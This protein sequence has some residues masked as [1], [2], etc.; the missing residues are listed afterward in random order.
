M[1]RKGFYYCLFFFVVNVSDIPPAT[2]STLTLSSR[3]ESD[4]CLTAT[5][6]TQGI[7]VA[8]GKGF[9]NGFDQLADPYGI[10]LDDN[11]T[12]YIADRSNHRIIMWEQNA[13]IGQLV[14]G[15]AWESTRSM[16]LNMPQDVV[17]DKNGTMYISDGGNRRVVRWRRDAEE[18][19]VIID[20]IQ[21]VGIGQDDEGSIYVSEYADGRITKW[22]MNDDE[23]NGQVIATQ[24]RQSNFL[25]VDQ[26][27]S[28]YSV[29]YMAHRIVKVSEDAEEPIIVAGQSDKSGRDLDQ[30]AFPTGVFVDQLG[31]IYVADTDNH[32]I[33]RW[34][35]GATSGNLIIGEHG[36]GSESDQLHNPSDLFLDRYGNLYVTDTLN[37]RVQKFMIDKSSCLTN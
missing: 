29:G 13:T 36:V 32:R 34:P 21:A 17:V 37:N 23:L 8:G 25:F 19:E 1:L 5:W 26:N 27:R 20:H 31:T 12:I 16:S 22:N 7:T 4:I 11:D 10:F 28:V 14:A 2:A 30:L 18:G 6:A 9:G 3:L 33:V 35:R 15:E 24:L